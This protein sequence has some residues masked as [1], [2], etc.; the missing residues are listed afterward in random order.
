[1]LLDGETSAT[2]VFSPLQE[3]DSGVYTCKE[4]GSTTNV[5][6]ELTVGGG[7]SSLKEDFSSF[8]NNTAPDLSVVITTSGQRAE[9]RNYSL[10]CEISGDERLAVSER[11][12]RWDKVGG[13]VAILSRESVL[14]FDALSPEDA[15][16]YRCTSIVTSPYLTGTRAVTGTE[17]VA[18]I[19][20]PF[21]FSL[22]IS[23]L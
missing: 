22:E 5:S 7:F 16:E 8:L 23:K 9:G 17:S 12:F 20:K 3:M 19:G 21:L 13:S 4:T 2:L 6:V 1:M 15:G 11:A 14:A 18:V 10:T